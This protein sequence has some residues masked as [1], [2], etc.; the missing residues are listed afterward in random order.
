[1]ICRE[2]LSGYTVGAGTQIPLFNSFS[3]PSLH[4]HWQPTMYEPLR[5][6][7][8]I[9]IFIP[10]TMHMQ[11]NMCSSLVLSTLLYV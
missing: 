6:S 10:N 2:K 1:M 9:M 11:C 4:L 3:L 7:I 8:A 5:S